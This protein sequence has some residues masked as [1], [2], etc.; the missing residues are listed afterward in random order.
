M[1]CTAQNFNVRTQLARHVMQLCDESLLGRAAGSEGE[2][3]AAKYLFESLRDA[4]VT[5]LTDERGQDFKMNLPS[6]ELSS[7]NIVGVVEGSDRKLCEEYIVVGAHFDHLGYN[8]L[9][10]DGV[11]T[12]QIFSGADSDASGVAILIELARMVAQYKALFPRTIIFVG[13][14]ASEKGNAGSWYF[15]NRAFEQIG[16]VKAMINLDMLGRIG[17]SNPFQLFSQ[18]SGRDAGFLLERAHEYPVVL[19]PSLEVTEVA[20]SDHLPFYE[21]H[22]PVFFFTTGMKREYHTLKDTPESLSYGDMEMECNYIYHFLMMLSSED[23]LPAIS[24][25]GEVTREVKAEKVYSPGDCDKKPQFFHSGELHFL[26]NWVYK[27]LKYPQSAVEEG[28]RG[29][30]TVSFIVEKDGSL[31]DVAI[32]RSVDPR[33]DDE[34]L[35]VVNVSPK[36]I[37]GQIG[38]KKVRV[39]MIL[40]VEFRLSSSKSSFGIKK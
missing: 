29:T 27:Y 1:V 15:A 23:S 35:R 6:G 24:P 26:Q 34:V 22:I 20:P 36:W 31:T 40:P 4:G 7:C 11:K 37:P 9:E 25:E 5:M 17:A 28:V 14:G 33:L 30:V 21:K 12:K 13:F 2:S 8:L 39:R 32:E 18:L 38:G 19:T 16:S 3:A 10:Q